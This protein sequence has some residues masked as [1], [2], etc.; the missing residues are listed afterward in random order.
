MSKSKSSKAAS[1]AQAAPKVGGSVKDSKYSFGHKDPG[2]FS[3]W[4]CLP[5]GMYAIS[6]RWYGSYDAAKDPRDIQVRAR[7]RKYLDR[8]R[9]SYIPE[10]GPD[11]GRAKE[12]TDYG[13]RAFV[14]AEDLARG[15]ARMAL[16]TDASGFKDHT[17]DNDLHGV[18]HQIWSAYVKLDDNSPYNYQGKGT[19]GTYAWTKPALNHVA[20][21]LDCLRFNH[22]W[23]AKDGTGYCVDCGAV[24]TE[25]L[26]EHGGYH[27]PAKYTY[28]YPPGA[29]VT[30]HPD[31]R[32]IVKTKWRR[33]PGGPE[34]AADVL[35]S[36]PRTTPVPPVVSHG[37]GYR[38]PEAER[39]RAEDCLKYAEHFWASGTGSPDTCQ[40]CGAVRILDP[41]TEEWRHYYPEGSAMLHDELGYDVDDPHL[42]T[43][44]EVTEPPADDGYEPEVYAAN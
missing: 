12:G 27:Y 23:N 38:T 34:V 43:A 25:V 28:T 14:S 22:W 37:L 10:L 18:Y 39:N 30:C 36:T 11:E 6:H 13:H 21:P 41:D 16:A 19:T 7:K 29:V 2:T 42:T 8:L 17:V 26:T 32:A 40:D 15:M 4:L 5:I 35:P 1:T 3:M 20:K 44:D 33:V 9:A 31:G 24:R